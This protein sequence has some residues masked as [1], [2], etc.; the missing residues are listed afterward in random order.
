MSDVFDVIVTDCGQPLVIDNIWHVHQH[1]YCQIKFKRHQ[2][3]CIT[4]YVHME[5][6]PL[7][8]KHITYRESLCLVCM[9]NKNA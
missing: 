5:P 4:P 9:I 2:F 6:I 7:E 3:N 1:C 8:Y